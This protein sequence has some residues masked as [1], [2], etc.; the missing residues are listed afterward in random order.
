[1]K[2]TLTR[3]P[4]ICIATYC[5]LAMPALAKEPTVLAA[6]GKG[7]MGISAVVGDSAISSYELENRLR[8]IIA[9]AHM[10]NTPEVIDRI[11][12][13]VMRSLIDERLQVQEAEKNGI[14]IADD[15]LEQAVMAIEQQRGMEPGSISRMLEAARIPRNTFT[16]QVRA[17]LAWN[18]L[19]MKKVK[20]QVRISDDEV[21]LAGKKIL[22]PKKEQQIQEI[23]IAVLQ[24]PVE[25]ASRLPEMQKLADKLVGEIRAG[26][27]FEEVSRQF[28]SGAAASG[29]K[30][31]SFWVRPEQ[32]SPAI[33][34]RLQTAQAG[35]VTDPVRSEQGLTIVKVYDVRA[36]ETP[37]ETQTDVAVAIKEI[38]LK[39]K[40][41][42][43]VD[44]ANV[45]LQ[46]GEDVAKNPGTCQEKGVANIGDLKDF[47]IEVNIYN[48]LMS[49][50]PPAVKVI[51]ENLQVGDISTPF[52]SSEGIRLYMLCDKKDSRGKLDRDR[53][54]AL[55][56]QQKMELE[57][58][59]YLRNL[60][61]DVFTDVR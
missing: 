60:R 52:A 44:E 61:R 51:A 40:P 53:V 37:E 19:L 34:Q 32:L 2:H 16:D 23:K 55:L 5:A 8:F 27:S 39:V 48:N 45:M 47:D 22:L 24:L 13:Q 3:L 43:S 50:L 6:T 46:I 57:A 35:M 28:S 18:K 10:S 9:T 14:T 59:K 29:G 58:Q 1:M 33:A 12:P 31:D 42:A 26:A 15:E 25:K 20:P 49:E 36:V 41:E 4:V 7:G 54:M 21:R 38:L 11:R 30:V 56:F 17:Q